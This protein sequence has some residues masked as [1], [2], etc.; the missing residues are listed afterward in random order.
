MNQLL[1][2]ILHL[3]ESTVIDYE[4]IE[5][6]T[7]CNFPL[8]VIRCNI[9][10][11]DLTSENQYFIS[12]EDVNGAHCVDWFT[13]RDQI[14]D[15]FALWTKLLQ[16]GNRNIDEYRFPTIFPVRK[17]TLIDRPYFDILTFDRQ[18]NINKAGKE[19]NKEDE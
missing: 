18:G 1:N 12:I 9:R 4:L 3:I 17:Y 6:N 19:K 11:S 10:K 15:R 13:H 8:R 7:V 16:R 5:E 14:K 2:T